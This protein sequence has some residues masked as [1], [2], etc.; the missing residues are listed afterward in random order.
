MPNGAYFLLSINLELV[1]DMTE[2][3]DSNPQEY[4]FSVCPG[5]YSPNVNPLVC[6]YPHVPKGSPR[7]ITV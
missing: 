5:L 2:L 7:K 4:V 6:S 3:S 1:W